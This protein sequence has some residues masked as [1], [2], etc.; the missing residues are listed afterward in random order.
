MRIETSGPGSG[1][2]MRG[3]KSRARLSEALTR[4]AVRFFPVAAALACVLAL[5]SAALTPTPCE[6]AT[7][8]VLHSFSGPPSEGADA[9]AGLIQATDGNFYGTTIFG[10]ASGT[11]TTF[12]MDASG[13]LTTLHSFAYSDGATPFAGLFQATDGNFYGTTEQGGASELGVIFRLSGPVR[14]PTSKNA[15]KNEGWRSLTRADGSPFKNQGDCIQYV[16][17]K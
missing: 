11:G 14:T 8:A 7:Y 9:T 15:C 10:G 6:A 1:D 2:C 16:N 3:A 17:G 13:N 5:A 12:K 4:K